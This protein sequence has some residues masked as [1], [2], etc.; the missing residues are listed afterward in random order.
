MQSNAFP[1]LF[2]CAIVCFSL[3]ERHPADRRNVWSERGARTDAALYPLACVLCAQRYSTSCTATSFSNGHSLGILWCF[4]L[5]WV[6]RFE[7]GDLGPAV[8]DSKLRAQKTKF[9]LRGRGLVLDLRAR[10]APA[11]L[12]SRLRPRDSS[13]TVKASR[14]ESRRDMPDRSWMT[15]GVYEAAQKPM[16]SVFSKVGSSVSSI[17]GMDSVVDASQKVR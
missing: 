14:T 1:E 15:C 13:R 16:G 12:S 4:S 3:T 17:P 8:F 7:I 5:S 10:G 9:S 11:L 6:E 2:A